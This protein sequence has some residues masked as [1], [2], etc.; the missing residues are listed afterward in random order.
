[1]RQQTKQ[2]I[3]SLL[4]Y[5]HCFQKNVFLGLLKTFLIQPSVL[6]L[7]LS[8]LCIINAVTLLLHWLLFVHTIKHDTFVCRSTVKLWALSGQ[9]LLDMIGHSSLVYSVDAHSSGLIASG[10]EDRSLKIW[11]GDIFC[12]I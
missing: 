8:V 7:H 12:I 1:M 4:T 9:P 10:S 11:K 5:A 2:A 3:N 6:C